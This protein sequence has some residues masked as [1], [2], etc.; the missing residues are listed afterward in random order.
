LCS[1]FIASGGGVVSGIVRLVDELCD[2]LVDFEPAQWP[3]SD[4]ADLAERLA[5]GAKACEAASARAAAR[6]ADC[7]ADRSRGDATARE[8]FARVS[9]S[10][11]GAARSALATAALLETCPAT[12]DALAAGDVSLAQAA[13]IMALPEHEEE[14]LQ[15]ARTS[16]LRAVKDAARKRRLAGIK[17]EELQAR[18]RA[19]RTFRHWKDALGMIRFRGALAPIDGV[20]FVN[21]LDAETDREWRAARR[22]QRDEP[23]RALAADAFVRMI[24][25]AS[26]TTKKS[27]SAD[28]VFV[29]DSRAYRRGHAHAGEPCHVIGGGPVPIEAVY[30]QIDD[31]FVKAVL[32]NGVDIQMVAHQGRRRPAALQTALE[33]GPAPAFEGV[34][35]AEPGCDRI[36]GLQWDHVDPCANGGV[37]SCG[38]MQPLCTPH[39]CKKTERDR[40]AGLLAGSKGERGP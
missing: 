27:R 19:A 22:E 31:A 32:H 11:G 13:Q 20:P 30:E 34:V 21:R 35:C 4:C 29:V 33:L 40:K 38:N 2:A 39:H 36:Y 15:L 24:R 18:Q 26:G 1:L 12:R 14:L 17:P 10:S 16:G 28:V 5:R 3:G 9:G 7:G 37:T 8:W 6:A 25:E 23:R